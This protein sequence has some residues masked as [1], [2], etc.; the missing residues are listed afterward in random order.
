MYDD[1]ADPCQ[2]KNLCDQRDPSAMLSELRGQLRDLLQASHDEFPP[3][4]RHAE[5]FNSQRD[6]VR[7][8]PGP[9][10]S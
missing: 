4:D 3:G 8:A 7:N 5:W 9:V 6:A 2:M 10:K 1:L